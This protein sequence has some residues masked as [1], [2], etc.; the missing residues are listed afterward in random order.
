MRAIP[1]KWTGTVMEPMFRF[2]DVCEK[3][4]EIGEIYKLVPEEEINP[5]SRS[6]FFASIHEAFRNLPE[7][8]SKR[9]PTE[10]H[11]RKWALVHCG[12]ADERQIVCENKRQ[13]AAAAAAVRLF[14]EYAVIKIR[15]KVV[16]AWKAQSQSGRAMGKENFQ[17]SKQAVLDLLSSM[18]GVDREALEERGRNPPA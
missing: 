6:H 3:Q 15:G 4:Y 1:F 10:T 17:R 11:L 12:Y 2:L 13:A 5:R 8:L 14:D 7:H 16:H 18:I 9:F